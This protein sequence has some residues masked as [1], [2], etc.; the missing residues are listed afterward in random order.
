MSRPFL[1]NEAARAFGPCPA[2]GLSWLL[3]GGNYFLA[4]RA[5]SRT[6]TIE[7]AREAM[8]DLMARVPELS[9]HIIT[10][11]AARRQQLI[12]R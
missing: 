7:V 10:V 3:G 9:D 6:V 1:G 12:T 5:V 2:R 11:F 4:M 8:L